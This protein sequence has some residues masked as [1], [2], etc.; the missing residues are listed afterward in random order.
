VFPIPPYHCACSG[1]VR[2]Y[3][4][5]KRVLLAALKDLA[6]ARAVK[7]RVTDAEACERVLVEN[8]RALLVSS[9]FALDHVLRV[10]EALHTLAIRTGCT[11]LA[12]LLALLRE[13][14]T[15]GTD[16]S[17]DVG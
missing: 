8:L 6:A 9:G 10:A 13:E 15:D 14:T 2:L 5:D 11:E 4:D 7:A 1:N 3:R 17:A 12:L 16:A